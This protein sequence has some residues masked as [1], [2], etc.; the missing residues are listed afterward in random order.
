MTLSPDVYSLG[1]YWYKNNSYLRSEVGTYAGL[2]VMQIASR[3]GLSF[4]SSVDSHA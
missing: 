2:L 4:T 3:R 1:V